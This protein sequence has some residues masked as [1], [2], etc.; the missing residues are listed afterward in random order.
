MRD[1]IKNNLYIGCPARMVLQATRADL[2]QHVNRKAE[3]YRMAC[4]I[5]N[6]IVMFPRS[7][8][9]RDHV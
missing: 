9:A 7:R 3:D 6:S 4:E 8:Q 5:Q 2:L 1:T